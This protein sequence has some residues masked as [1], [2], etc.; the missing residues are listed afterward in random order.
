[1]IKNIENIV[2]EFKKPLIE[3]SIIHQ[4]IAVILG[5]LALIFVISRIVIW[6]KCY[7]KSISTARSTHWFFDSF[8][9]S[10]VIEKI[11]LA[12]AQ[13]F[14]FKKSKIFLISIGIYGFIYLLGGIFSIIGKNSMALKGLCTVIC[15]ICANALYI[16]FP[17]TILLIAIVVVNLISIYC[18]PATLV[19]GVYF[20]FSDIGWKNSVADF[21]FHKTY[22]LP[23]DVLH[24][25]KVI[26]L[27]C[28]IPVAFITSIK[29]MVAV[30]K[31]IKWTYFAFRERFRHTFLFFNIRKNVW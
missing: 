1:M 7:R 9:G 22:E 8:R 13:R 12:K 20:I 3:G 23:L 11:E 16:L 6:V 18:I 14:M 4:V 17:A 21:F 25:L 2:L 24:V 29:L 19:W 28:L 15:T 10:R 5:I 26:G 27:F 31:W 30:G